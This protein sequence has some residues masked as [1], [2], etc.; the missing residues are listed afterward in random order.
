MVGRGANHQVWQNTTYETLPS[1][2]IVPHIHEYT[3]LATGLNFKDENG[4]WVASSEEIEGS[5]NGSIARHGQHSVTFANNPNTSVAIDMHTP[6]LKR[7]QSHVMG[8]SY[9]DTA[10]GSNV[11]IAEVKDCQGVIMPPDQVLYPNAFTDNN[12]PNWPRPHGPKSFG[13]GLAKHYAQP[14]SVGGPPQVSC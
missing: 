2:R 12:W 4:Q 6:D 10:S 11:W 5:A 14:L 3:E 13:L 7:L 1:R 9:L 8:L